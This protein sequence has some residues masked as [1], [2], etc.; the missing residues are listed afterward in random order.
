MSYL[1]LLVLAAIAGWLAYRYYLQP[2]RKPAARPAT[3]RNEAPAR[4]R[5]PSTTLERDPKTGVYRPVDD[6]E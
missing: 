4:P 3:R 5:I 6:K 1:T 2:S